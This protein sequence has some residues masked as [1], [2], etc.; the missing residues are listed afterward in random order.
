MNDAKSIGLSINIPHEKTKSHADIEKNF[1]KFSDRLDNFVVMANAI[2]VAPGG[3]GTMLELFYT[4]QLL[5]THKIKNI[6]VILL[7]DI[8][9][10]LMK[11]IKAHPVRHKF[12]DDE[13]LKL[14]HVANNAHE[15][16]EIIDAEYK[17]YAK[18]NKS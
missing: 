17:K 15:A 8:W 18:K 3:I 12:I 1:T 9:A 2:V 13:D 16:I 6:P 5:Q 11:W 7:G 14:V 4:W 10:D